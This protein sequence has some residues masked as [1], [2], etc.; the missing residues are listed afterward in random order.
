MLR[1]AVFDF[2]G[3][4]V[5]SHPLHVRA[6]KHFLDSVGKTVT[7]EQLLFAL[8][9]RKRD[10]ILRHFMGELEA[11]QI[12]EYGLRKEQFF[13]KEAVHVRTADGLLNFLEDLQSEQLA[14]AIASSGGKSRIYFLLD[15]LGLRKFFRAVVTG[16]EVEQGKPHPA[17]F[18]MAAHRLGVD[19][20]EVMAF[21]DAVSGVQAARSAGM[22]CVGI[23][24][25]DRAP[26]LLA[27]GANPVVPDFYSLSCSKL[28][29]LLSNGAGTR[30][31]STLR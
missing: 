22:K 13:R 4:I 19:P 30:S 3:V 16:D 21:E 15:R 20:T 25:L 6:W 10:D 26:I 27:A 28:R 24:Q 9:G 7:E 12:I 1:G 2:D 17:V 18:L 14:L 29:E 31:M 11:D 8:D 23:A 5:D